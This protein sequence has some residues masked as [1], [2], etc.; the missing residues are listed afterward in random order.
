MSISGKD[1]SVSVDSGS[2]FEGH[3]FTINTSGQEEDLRIF[4]SS[5]T[6]G[7]WKACNQSGTVTINTY[8]DPGD[9]VSDESDVVCVCGTGADKKTYTMNSSVCTAWDVDVDAKACA[10]EY[11]TT[12]R[13]TELTTS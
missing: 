10:I 5:K 3:K 12:Y 7:D 13:I 1:C 2:S 11:T 4:G 9:R 8:L 6:Y